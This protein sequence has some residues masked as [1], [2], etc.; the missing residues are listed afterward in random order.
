[1]NKKGQ[2]YIFIAMILLAYLTSLRPSLD[3]QRSPQTYYSQYRENFLTELGYV[4]NSALFDDEQM[5]GRVDEYVQDYQGYLASQDINMTLVLFL[6]Q[7]DMLHI[8]NYNSF[9]LALTLYNGTQEDLLYVFSADT[10]SV[11]R[12]NRIGVNLTGE[13][14]NE[15]YTITL[16]ASRDIDV[17]AIFKFL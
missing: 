15:E 2:F 12:I 3:T 5:L 9:P 13:H 1:M 11:Q 17:K 10:V 16:D 6:G 7:G 4:L 8:K 14:I